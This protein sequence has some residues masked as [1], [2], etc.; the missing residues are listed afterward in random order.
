MSIST[1]DIIADSL[2]YY[3]S[4]VEYFKKLKKKIKYISKHESTDKYTA[5]YINLSFL[6]K[7]KKIL[8]TSRIEIIGKYF[9]PEKVWIWGWSLPFDKS[10]IS[11]IRNLFMYGTDIDVTYEGNQSFEKF[12]LKSMLTTSRFAVDDIVQVEIFCGLSSYLTKKPLIIPITQSQLRYVAKGDVVN[13]SL[14]EYLNPDNLRN[15]EESVSFIYVLDP[16]DV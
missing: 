15:I 8:F 16:P 2:E 10:Y 11:T 4:N 13:C 14:D 12:F 9:G 3:D 5:K 6:D 7:D 1:I